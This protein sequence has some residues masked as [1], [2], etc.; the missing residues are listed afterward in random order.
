MLYATFMPLGVTTYL[1]LIDFF[2]NF[3]YIPYNSLRNP[4]CH[5]TEHELTWTPK[6]EALWHISQ[7]S[8]VSAN[9][10]WRKAESACKK[11]RLIRTETWSMKNGNWRNFFFPELHTGISDYSIQNIQF[12][13]H[14]VISNAAGYNTAFCS[15]KIWAWFKT[16]LWKYHLYQ[17]S[18]SVFISYRKW[19]KSLEVSTKSESLHRCL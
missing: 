12:Y 7:F 18:S 6:F 17:W 4:C 2:A 14:Q 19:L 10:Q 9:R 3:F 5:F 16:L 15:Y 13:F 1:Q 11:S 8:M